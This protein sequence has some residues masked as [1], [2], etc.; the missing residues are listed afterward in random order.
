V[1]RACPF[2]LRHVDCCIRRVIAADNTIVLLPCR[3]HRSQ[4]LYSKGVL[5]AAARH[6]GLVPAACDPIRSAAQIDG[7]RLNRLSHFTLPT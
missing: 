7:G 4:R 6:F 3:R 1:T 2:L 5:S